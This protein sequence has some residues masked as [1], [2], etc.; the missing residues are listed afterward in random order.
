MGVYKNPNV[1]M[2]IGYCIVI[3]LTVL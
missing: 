3:L 1:K 2:F